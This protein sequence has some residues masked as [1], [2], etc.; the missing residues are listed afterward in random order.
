[1]ISFK[2]FLQES[3]SQEL[4]PAEETFRQIKK[5][6]EKF[7]TDAEDMF[8]LLRGTG[9]KY[10]S[11]TKFQQPTNRPPRDS[12]KK[13]DTY[14]NQ[15]FE[16][17]FGISNLRRTSY[18]G[19]YSWSAAKQ[20]GEVHY[21]FPIGDYKICSSEEIYD[22]LNDVSKIYANVA[23]N[24][25]KTN[26][27]FETYLSLPE[28]ITDIVSI[29][30]SDY[31]STH[32]DGII[33]FFRNYAEHNSMV[34]IPDEMAYQFRNTIEDLSVKE[35]AKQYKIADKLKDLEFLS[36]ASK[37]EIMFYKGDG[38]Y[39]IKPKT[40]LDYLG[41]RGLETSYEGLIK[42]VKNI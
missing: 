19:T 21:L 12:T 27:E 34:Q 40:A 15:M 39:L 33:D 18:F 24:F 1:M 5:D 41:S 22:L 30:F 20:Y 13:Q 42:Y 6:C 26:R 11:L 8:P 23:N 10:Y 38:Y 37:T 9:S 28:D 3:Y 36:N 14:Y 17:A 2:Q 4:P 35:F 16:Q 31:Y 29:Y 25:I 7:L 32:K